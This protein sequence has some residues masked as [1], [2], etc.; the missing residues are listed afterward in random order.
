MLHVSREFSQGVALVFQASIAMDFS[1]FASVGVARSAVRERGR[2]LGVVFPSPGRPVRFALT[3]SAF[4][5]TCG[6][7]ALCNAPPATPTPTDSQD[8]PSS[9]NHPLHPPPT[10]AIMFPA[11][12]GRRNDRF[13]A[14]LDQ[15]FAPAAALGDKLS[16]PGQVSPGVVL[17]FQATT[18]PPASFSRHP[19]RSVGVYLPSA[20]CAVGL[21]IAEP[22]PIV[23][24]GHPG[25]LEFSTRSPNA[26]ETV[27]TRRRAR[28]ASSVSLRA[29]STPTGD[30]RHVSAESSEGVPR[31]P[32]AITASHLYKQDNWLFGTSYRGSNSYYTWDGSAIFHTNIRADGAASDVDAIHRRAERLHNPLPSYRF[33]GR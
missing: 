30:K 28:A 11:S 33:V 17:A 29:I 8:A 6:H 2:G 10:H 20:R 26:A 3:A 5:V 24:C 32:R 19:S 12:P 4:A 22:I 1:S 14:A 13:F 15:L 18:M 9:A 31:V 23:K 16:V 7:L 25:P 21:S 27:E